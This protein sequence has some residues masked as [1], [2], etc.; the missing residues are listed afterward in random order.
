MQAHDDPPTFARGAKRIGNGNGNGNGKNIWI[1]DLSFVISTMTDS[2]ALRSRADG[3]LRLRPMTPADIPLGMRLK[4]IAGW[5]QTP[6]DWT[7]FLEL[8]PDGCFVAE[9]D[10]V[11]V[12]T[13][14]TVDHGGRVGWV[15]MVLVDPGYR[16][17]GIGTFLIESALEVLEGRCRTVKLDATPAGREVYLPLGFQDELLLERRIRA[18]G[19]STFL[20]K[21]PKI[22]IAAC[23]AAHLAEVVAFDIEAFGADRSG[24]LKRWHRGT[25]ERAFVARSA[26]RLSGFCL[27]RHG[28]RHE[29]VGPLVAVNA[30]TAEALLQGALETCPD[31]SVV[32]DALTTDTRWIDT[33]ERLEFRLERRL[34]RMARG[35][36][37]PPG[38]V[39]WLWAAAG[40]EVG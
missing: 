5:N 17:R 39:S 8:C 4:D 26:G 25:P 14:T 40:P 24:I 9:W 22:E 11:P 6:A 36:E 28:S 21:D 18:A 33:L 27:G 38:R 35:G 31:S 10:G 1:L 7:N 16:R 13:F 3:P 12:G 32:I 15:G 30:E 29:Q 2:I 19:S 34:T 37:P 23:R 20:A